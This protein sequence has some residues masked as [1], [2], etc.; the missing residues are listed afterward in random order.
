MR[1]DPHKQ[2][3]TSKK[4]QARSNKQE[5][6]TTTLNRPQEECNEELISMEEFMNKMR[7]F[8][9]LNETSPYPRDTNKYVYKIDVDNIFRRVHL[10]KAFEIILDYFEAQV[11][12]ENMSDDLIVERTNYLLDRCLYNDELKQV[13]IYAIY[14]SGKQDD[15]SDDD[16]SDDETGDESDD[17]TGDESDESDDETD[18]E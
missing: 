7:S 14:K 13:V 10:L 11:Y 18:E 1:Y 6:V 16:E 17:E 5:M 9:T 4:Q 3:A 15:E 8:N 2:Y 12:D